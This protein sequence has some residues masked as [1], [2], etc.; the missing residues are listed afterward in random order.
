[1]YLPQDGRGEGLLGEELLDW[2]N[3]V[4]T[5]PNNEQGN[6]IMQTKEPYQHPSFWPYIN[7][8]LLRGF[9]LPASSFLRTLQSHPHA[10]ISKL[11]LLLSTHLSLFPRS[12][13]TASYPLDHQFLTAHK[14]W[15][16]RFRA[17]LAAFVGGKP[18]GK[19]FETGVT[20][21]SGGGRGEWTIWEDDF[22]AVIE[23]MEGRVERVLEESADWREALG[24]WGVLVDVGLRRDDLPYVISYLSGNDG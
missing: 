24:A 10:P 11:A 8:C 16:G 19:W 21:E 5:A 22:R 15:L 20:G 18:R 9:H 2:V 6:E 12:H 3:A 4:D 17:E 14:T 1:M 13:N 23:L 7:R